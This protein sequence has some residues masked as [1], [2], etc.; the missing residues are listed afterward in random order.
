MLCWT[1]DTVTV[2]SRAYGSD[3]QED[4]APISAIVVGLNEGHLLRECLASASFCDQKLYVDLGSRDSSLAIAQELG[5]E[6]QSHD[7]VPIGEFI[8]SELKFSMKNPW[9]LFLDPDERISPAL[10]SS[11]LKLFRKGLPSSIG[12]LS[13]PWFFH[14]KGKR[15]HGTPWGGVKSRPFVA[16][17]ERFSL[18][19][20]VHRGRELLDGFETYHF[21]ADNSGEFINHFWSAS[22]KDL[23]LKH[24]RYLNLE[25]ESQFSAGRHTTLR[26]LLLSL[27]RLALQ[28]VKHKE[29]FSDGVLGV[30]L[31]LFWIVY[32]FLAE[33]EL[34]RYQKRRTKSV[35]PG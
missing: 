34:F 33:W 16:H 28:V 32:K 31:S 25:G 18:T 27:P 9:I 2:H 35:R 19:T 12:A 21:G 10:G 22:W 29:P 24:R 4:A 7:R 14:F 26:R 13:A 1:G 8:V 17:R 6:T 23:I 30:G 11:V 15:L 20:E 5:W 3:T